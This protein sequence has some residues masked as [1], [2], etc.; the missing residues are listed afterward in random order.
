MFILGTSQHKMIN[1]RTLDSPLNACFYFLFR[2][3]CGNFTLVHTI[4]SPG[5]KNYLMKTGVRLFWFVQIFT[6]RVRRFLRLGATSCISGL[7]R[8]IY[9]CN[10]T[11]LKKTKKLNSVVLVR[12][13]TIPTERPQPAGEVS[14]NFS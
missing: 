2:S 11:K 7:R 5:H 14:A 1:I 4:H 10:V 12:K 13:R 6:A 8:V 3:V 9:F